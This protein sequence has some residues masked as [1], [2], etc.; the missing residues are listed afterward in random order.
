M[1]L[2]APAMPNARASELPI[3]II[4]S[5]PATASSTCAC[6]IEG[7]TTRSGKTRRWTAVTASPISAATTSFREIEEWRF[8]CR[9]GLPGPVE[10]HGEGGHETADT[11]AQFRLMQHERRGGPE[12]GRSQPPGAR[13]GTWAS[14][15]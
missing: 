14:R 2:A 3:T 10:R 8:E 7:V 12:R 6:S 11:S 4:I 1:T 15:G 5:A 9:G 13:S